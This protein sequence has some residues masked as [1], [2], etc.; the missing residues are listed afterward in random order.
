MVVINFICVKGS[1]VVLE[2]IREKFRLDFMPRESPH[3]SALLR[4]NLKALSINGDK[5]ID[6]INES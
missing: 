2:E 1:K 6:R 3:K 5:E 4:F